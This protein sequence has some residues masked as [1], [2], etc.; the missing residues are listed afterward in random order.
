MNIGRCKH[1]LAYIGK[2]NVFIMGGVRGKSAIKDCWKYD[3]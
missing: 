2:N 1:W 3:L